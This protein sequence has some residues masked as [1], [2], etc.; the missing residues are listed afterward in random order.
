MLNFT[1][2]DKNDHRLVVEAA[3][4]VAAAQVGY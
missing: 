2:G 4:A 3:F 1:M